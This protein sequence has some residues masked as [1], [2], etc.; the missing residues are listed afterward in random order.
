MTYRFGESRQLLCLLPAKDVEAVRKR[1]EE[2]YVW[3]D[4]CGKDVQF[5]LNFIRCVN[6]YCAGLCGK[7]LTPMYNGY[8]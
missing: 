3:Y 5:T 7:V 6:Y 4:K 1:E 2:E 8:H